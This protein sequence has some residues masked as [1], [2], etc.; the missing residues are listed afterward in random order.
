MLLFTVSAPTWGVVDL[1]FYSVVLWGAVVFY[2]VA[3]LGLIYSA[4]FHAEKIMFLSTWVAAIGL[5]CQTIA[6]GMRWVEV[7][8]GPYIGFFDAV[9]SF[10]FVSSAAYLALVAWKPSL[11]A[12]GDIIMPVA[13]IFLGVAMM[14]SPSDMGITPALASIWLIVHVFFAKVA[15]AAMVIAFALAVVYIL[16]DRGKDIKILNQ[17][18]S[19]SFLDDTVFR[20]VS[21]GFIVWTIMIII[22]AVWANEAWGRY[23]G[24][25]PIET[26]SLI[27]WIVYA[28]CLHLR[29]TRGWKGRRFAY[30]TIA[31]LPLMLF[32]LIG[33]PFVWDSIHAAY[34]S[35]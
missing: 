7:G 14:T 2:A 29:L 24:W 30:L 21:I 9:S 33:V 15:V 20:F 34:L 17:L 10:A 18:P 32:A 11:K 5:V 1:D 3:S 23:W 19:Q 16:R 25:D 12:I 27:A 26:W 22:G 28:I 31:A 8:H 6:I 13:F 4:V 35:I